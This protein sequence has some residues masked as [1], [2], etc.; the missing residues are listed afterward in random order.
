MEVWALEGYGAAHTSQEM[1][2]IK[3]DDIMGRVGAYEAILKGE[4]I[5]SP[6][7]P[8]SFN[9]LISELKS[10]SLNFEIREAPM[11]R[12]SFKSEAGEEAKPAE[13]KAEEKGAKEKN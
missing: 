4:K 10:L 9:L 2:T 12:E 11:A 5:R 8:A 7:V 13:E 6:N 3:S 1:L